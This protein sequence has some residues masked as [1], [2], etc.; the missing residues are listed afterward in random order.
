MTVPRFIIIY[1]RVI[2]VITAIIGVILLLHPAIAHLFFTSLNDGTIFFTRIIGS[3]L[4][5]YAALNGITSFY[6]HNSITFMVS[7]WSNFVTLF[8]A[9][10]LCTL[11]AGMLDSNAWLIIVQHYLFTLGFF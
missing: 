3:T 4:L 10:V 2:A 7:A 9:S 8:I 5:G 11:Y 6:A 1:F